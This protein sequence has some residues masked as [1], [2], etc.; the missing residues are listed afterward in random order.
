MGL[1]LEPPVCTAEAEKRSPIE[2][3]QPQPLTILTACFTAQRF[4]PSGNVRRNAATCTLRVVSST[5]PAQTCGISTCLLRTRLGAR[6][7]LSC[8][9]E[10]FLSAPTLPPA[11]FSET[12]QTTVSPDFPA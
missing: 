12:S 6:T 3:R 5:M 2:N 1:A 7:V 8:G 10:Y 11:L 9:I 4:W